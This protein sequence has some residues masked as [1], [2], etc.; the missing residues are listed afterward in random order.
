MLCSLRSPSNVTICDV[1]VSALQVL[2]LYLLSL[3]ERPIL[4]LLSCLFR[5]P[6]T[7]PNPV[8][9]SDKGIFTWRSGVISLQKHWIASTMSTFEYPLPRSD[10]RKRTSQMTAFSTSVNASLF[11]SGRGLVAGVRELVD[12]RWNV[13]LG[14]RAMMSGRRTKIP[15]FLAAMAVLHAAFFASRPGT[16]FRHSEVVR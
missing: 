14:L 3:H 7:Y 1:I 11:C 5:N 10:R 4:P 15:Q 16:V 13:Y 2:H 12:I 9:R 8:L 6:R